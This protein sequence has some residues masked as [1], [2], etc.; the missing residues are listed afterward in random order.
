MRE[1]LAYDAAPH[2]PHHFARHRMTEPTARRRLPPGVAPAAA[3]RPG[4]RALSKEDKRRRIAAAA[5]EVFVNEGYDNATTRAIAARADVSVGTVFVYAKDKRDL[6][7]MVINDELDALTA[8]GMRAA[9][10]DEPFVDALM[11]FFRARYRYWAR[12]PELSRPAMRE[13]FD[14]AGSPADAPGQETQR[15]YARRAV[16]MRH[17]S[18]LARA[19][20][21]RGEL[22]C[23]V[24]AER[25]ADLAFSLYLI[26]VR[27]WLA[28]P[29]PRVALG[30]AS[31]RGLVELA[32]RGVR[33]A[34]PP[35]RKG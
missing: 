20:Q 11:R 28:Q 5:R 10:A 26:E 16:L 23:D 1:V 6:L 18:G 34:L 32:M 24:P 2:R 3:A 8:Q 27:R 33:L 14:F 9:A 22:A 35:G 31:L 25:I 29:E 30:L 13:T 12:E 17:L 19:A 4:R 7:M 21:A 15:F